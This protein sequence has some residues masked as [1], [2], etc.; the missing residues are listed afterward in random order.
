MFQDKIGLRWFKWCFKCVSMVFE[1]YFPGVSW[2]LEGS[3]KDIFSKIQ[4]RFNNAPKVLKRK[5]PRYIKASSVNFKGAS[6]RFWRC[7][8]G[9]LQ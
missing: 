5:F 6:K 8:E 1:E 9:S 2:V 3:L 4:E 7:W